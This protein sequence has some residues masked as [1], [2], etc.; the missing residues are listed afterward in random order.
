M[1]DRFAVLGTLYVLHFEP[2]YKHARHYLGWT[3]GDVH[4]RL[5][6][7]LSGRG[8]NLVRVAINAGCAVT[9]I[10]TF[11]GTRYDERRLKNRGGS[12]RVCTACRAARGLPPY[13]VK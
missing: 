11:P 3:E 2:A 4:A 1:K 10:C 12:A 5:A 9:L 13:R 8:A 6:D 7:H